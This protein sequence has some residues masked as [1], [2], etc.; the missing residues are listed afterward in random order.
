MFRTS[1]FISLFDEI[2]LN[3]NFVFI[4]MGMLAKPAGHN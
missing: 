2:N 3:N 4:D 1:G